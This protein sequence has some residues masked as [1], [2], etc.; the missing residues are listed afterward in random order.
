MQQPGRPI[1]GEKRDNRLSYERRAGRESL[2]FVA[3]HCL[4]T[5][6]SASYIS[7]KGRAL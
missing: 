2:L 4:E 1:D 5:A 6:D 3:K 7:E